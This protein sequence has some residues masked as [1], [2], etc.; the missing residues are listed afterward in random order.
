[1]IEISIYQSDEGKL[2]R[3]IGR[4][5]SPV[6]PRKDDYIFF[7]NKTLQV[8]QIRHLVNAPRNDGFNWVDLLVKVL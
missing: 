4:Y 3:F 7:G 8:V 1:M 5:E 6:L 2:G